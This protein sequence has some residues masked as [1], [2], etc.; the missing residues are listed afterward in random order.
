MRAPALLLV[1][2][3]LLLSAC[4]KDPALPIEEVQTGTTPLALEI[5]LWALNQPLPLNLPADNPLTVEGVA[6]GRKLFYEKALSDN[7]SMSCGSCHQQQFAFTDPRRFSLGT[8]GSEGRRNSMSVQNMLWDHFFFRDGRAGSLEQQ[9]LGPV[10]NHV[11]LR[12]TWPV[13]EARLRRLPD[14]PQLFARVFGSPGID[15]IRVVKAIA[16]FERTLLSFDS[17]FDRYF[18]QGDANAMT[19]AEVRGMDLFF[20]E[21]QCDLCHLAPFFQDH[22]FRNIG[23]APGPDQGL[24]ELT[25]QTQ[26]RGRFK[27]TSLRN[28]ALTAPYMHDGRFAT[29]EEVIDFYADSVNVNDPNLDNHMWPWTGG[30]IDLSA[31]ERADLKAFMEALTDQRFVTDPAFSD[32]N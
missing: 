23:L 8:D 32:P 26:D 24:A 6:L 5:P 1:L 18:Y 29:L 27:V 2:S 22:D 3:L 14:Y 7:Y 17:P 9:A 31:E 10:V 30:Q 12:N 21:A 13:V 28:I 16:Q 11:E 25:G 19:D 20:G 15:S 4:R